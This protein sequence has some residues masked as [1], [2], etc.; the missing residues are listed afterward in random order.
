M[1]TL[2]LIIF[3]VKFQDM[4]QD[5]IITMYLEITLHRVLTM[6]KAPMT[7]HKVQEQPGRVKVIIHIDVKG[8][9]VLTQ[10]YIELNVTLQS[11]YQYI[12]IYMNV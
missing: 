3:F 11:M 4:A 1:N 6:P 5:L 8:I 10:C 2:F 7:I 12:L 9:K